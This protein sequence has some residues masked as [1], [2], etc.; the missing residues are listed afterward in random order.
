MNNILWTIINIFAVLLSPIIALLIAKKLQ[1]KEEKRKEKVYIL[2]VLMTQR[3]S[4]K[5]IDFVNALNLI[6]IIFVDD[7]LVREAY[8][9][10]YNAYA[11][12]VDTNNNDEVLAYCT[13]IKKKTTKLIESIVKNIGYKDK[14]TWD[15]IQEPYIPQW[16]HDE[17]IA[18]SEMN[19]AQVQL[20][21]FI[22]TI[23]PQGSTDKQAQEQ[24]K[25]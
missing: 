10:L 25:Q 19:S 6:D 1:E 9:N 8:K 15:T 4:I 5:S 7:K 17:L 21:N 18:K 24:K 13:G 20:V 2:K 23:T 3:F 22:K 11:V 12:K 16:L 14:I